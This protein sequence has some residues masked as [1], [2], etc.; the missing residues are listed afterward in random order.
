MNDTYENKCP[1]QIYGNTKYTNSWKNSNQNA[2]DQR[3]NSKECFVRNEKLSG[4][5]KLTTTDKKA[6]ASE[7]D[8]RKGNTA[9][10]DNPRKKGLND[11]S[12]SEFL[13]DRLDDDDST[14]HSNNELTLGSPANKNPMENLNGERLSF[15]RFISSFSNV[16]KEVNND[17]NPIIPTNV[18]QATSFREKEVNERLSID[19]S[20]DHTDGSGS[21]TALQD[22][23]A[24]K[25]LSTEIYEEQP[26]C[27]T[28]ALDALLHI[29][30][31]DTGSSS[32]PNMHLLSP[33][34]IIRKAFQSSVLSDNEPFPR[35]STSTVALDSQA[36]TE[37]QPM[38][39]HLDQGSV[40]I[41]QNMHPNTNFQIVT[42]PDV[43]RAASLI[44]LIVCPIISVETGLQTDAR[45]NLFSSTN[46]KEP[47]V[48]SSESQPVFL[49]GNQKEKR[50]KCSVNGLFMV[51]YNKV[52]ELC[53][54]LSE[55]KSPVKSGRGEHFNPT[56]GLIKK[57]IIQSHMF[58]REIER[59]Y[60]GKSDNPVKLL[61]RQLPFSVAL[62]HTRSAVAEKKDSQFALDFNI[63]NRNN[64]FVKEYELAIA[65]QEEL[66]DEFNDDEVREM[67]FS[68]VQEY[69]DVRENRTNASVVDCDYIIQSL[70]QLQKILL[71]EKNINSKVSTAYLSSILNHQLMVFFKDH[72]NLK[73]LFIPEIR[74]LEKHLPKKGL[75]Y[76][77]C[78]LRPYLLLLFS[79]TKL[80]C[81]FSNMSRT[82][83]GNFFVMPETRLSRSRFAMITLLI[84]EVLMV[85][86]FNGLG[87]RKITITKYIYFIRCESIFLLSDH[88][89]NI[90]HEYKEFNPLSFFFFTFFDTEGSRKSLGLNSGDLCTTCSIPRRLS[91]K[92]KG[93]IKNSQCADLLQVIKGINC[94]SYD[95]GECDVQLHY[96][97]KFKYYSQYLNRLKC[98]LI[99]EHQRIWQ[100]HINPGF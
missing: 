17:Q 96:I 98:I 12:G 100:S 11:N 32:G 55:N 72:I 92:F 85:G 86:L 90:S 69:A 97:E 33:D 48:S 40:F 65:S 88:G 60:K 52:S 93:F 7:K 22:T 20:R 79:L 31:D 8:L 41:V 57:L 87:V 77:S 37:S 94:T 4:S 64:F 29:S 35:N 84:R 42:Q 68:L 50:G 66:G 14:E 74:T 80:N 59:L 23:Q 30:R 53:S 34:D 9:F 18:C 28:T 25:S 47:S 21:I 24:E 82:N 39:L 63:L 36:M 78:R 71:E 75:M 61:C 15:P 62:Y 91:T 56:P 58:M 38:F 19:R 1:R 89:C 95:I 16:S 46:E 43:L 44:P 6:C 3:E 27:P 49:Q 10:T 81:F 70:D 45:F 73:L 54:L 5:K 99:S 51:F 13:I 26:S 76:H 2:H 67:V 83:L